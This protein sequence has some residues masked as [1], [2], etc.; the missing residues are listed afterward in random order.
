MI[1]IQNSS[2]QLHSLNQMRRSISGGKSTCNANTK[3]TWER[4]QQF[5]TTET[6]TKK[7]QATWQWPVPQDSTLSQQL[8][9]FGSWMSHKIPS[10]DKQEPSEFQRGRD[11]GYEEGFKDGIWKGM[12]MTALYGSAMVGISTIFRRLYPNQ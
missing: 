11:L 4:E 12:S 2:L 3:Y 6:V 8:Q 5:K 10:T 7:K 9:K 1:R